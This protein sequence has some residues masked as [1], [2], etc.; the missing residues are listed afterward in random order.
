MF[1]LNI[2]RLESMRIIIRNIFRR[3]NMSSI[4]KNIYKYT[5]PRVHAPL[6][7]VR[8]A[9]LERQ[10]AAARAARVRCCPC[11]AMKR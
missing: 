11:A 5:H 3:I 8:K 10:F 7:P 6:G 9:R 4:G 1:F 2:K